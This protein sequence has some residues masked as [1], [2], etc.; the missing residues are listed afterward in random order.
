MCLFVAARKD[1]SMLLVD[2]C[3][4]GGGTQDG[5]I[6]GAARQS[7]ESP[8][9][10][11]AQS[12]Y[13]EEEYALIKHAKQIVETKAEELVTKYSQLIEQSEATRLAETVKKVEKRMK[14]NGLFCLYWKEISI[15]LFG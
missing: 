7:S 2:R 13:S 9:L 8:L 6:V 1:A 14:V 3:G 4:G 15:Y 5:L 11:E 12:H 10:L